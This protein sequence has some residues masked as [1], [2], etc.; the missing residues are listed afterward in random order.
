MLVGDR[1][2]YLGIVLGI[3]FG[4]FLIAQQASIFCGV[5]LRTT[6]TIRDVK[7]ADIWVMDP[8]L[9]FMDDI[10]PLAAS[11]VYRVRGVD[12]VR[13]AVPFYKG[14]GRAELP[15]GDFQQVFVVGLDDGSLAGA[16]PQM[17][18]GRW[19]DLRASDAVIL[20]DAG[21]E[22]LWPNEPYRKGHTFELHDR[23]AEVAGVCRASRTFQ[24]FPQVFTLFSRAMTY[25]PQE[26]RTVSFILV[27]AQEGADLERVCRNIREQTG[28]VALTGEDFIW[29]THYFYMTR[30]GIPLNFGITVMLGFLVGCAISGQTFYL[31]T[32]EHLKH[33]ATLKA[34]G[35]T[36]WR[37]VS[38]VVLQA[39]V[40]G[41]IGYGLGVG[42]ASLFGEFA[43]GSPQLAFHM[44]WHVLVGTGA[45]VL[46]MVGGSSVLSVRR[47]LVV[48][49]AVV[50]QS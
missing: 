32:L 49:P 17:L 47:A 16:P 15:N 20:D 48:E 43:K 8:M 23:R 30:T 46:L 7:Q 4:A 22:M 41:S 39:L 24:T 25:A 31:F 9:H 19:E 18:L 50:F 37:I 5:M 11:D 27:R 10:K 28:L 35:A 40:V 38:M 1:A 12:G 33:F 3:A 13:W 42:A 6:G 34:M 2:K 21:Y 44:P 45:A 36:S 14:L 26:R 29:K